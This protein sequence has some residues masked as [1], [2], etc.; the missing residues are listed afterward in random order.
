MKNILVFIALLAAGYNAFSQ[1]APKPYGALPSARQI[2]WQETD[3]YC[4]IHFSMATYTDKEWG[5]GDEDP[6]IFN[7][8]SFSAIQ[9][10]SAAKAGGF[11]G[12]VVVAKHHDGFCLW[13]TK[14]TKHNISYSPF[15][16][17]KGDLVKEYQLACLK[18]GMKMGVY[19]S[20]WDRNNALYGKPEY[21]T[22]V[23]QKQLEE[24]Y[25]N[26]GRL[27]MSWHDGANGGDG[28]YGGTCEVRKIDRSNYYDWTTTWGITRK[29]QPGASIFGDVGPDVRWVGNEDGHAGDPYWATYTPEAPEP[30][31]MPANGFVKDKEGTEGTRNGNNWMPAECDVPLRSGWFYHAS[32]AGKSKSA[33]TLLDLYYRSVGRG[34]C[35]DL[36]LSPNKDGELDNEDVAIL[37]QFGLLLKETFKTNYATG[38][39]FKA[40]NI[41]GNSSKFGTS[42]LLDNNRYSYW[43]TDDNVTNPKL[44]VN[45]PG[46]K[47]FNVIRLRENIKLGQ[48][49][50]GVTIDAWKS[51]SWKQIGTLKSIGANRLMRLPAN[52]TTNKLRLK[53]KSP[54]CIAL[55]D[56]G[57][58]KEPVHL[59]P[60]VI[61]PNN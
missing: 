12:I 42:N 7:P 25:A 20:P 22:E 50:D 3:M 38:A 47:T 2:N 23:Y 49:I 35:L 41:R 28:Y 31:K 36:G 57:L 43:A 45:L 34:A 61:T 6:S 30:G 10:V 8:K 56:L 19:C 14:T 51:N 39:T 46:I 44:T 13:P 21:V 11:K 1:T 53:F 24:L 54:V 59:Q 55:S 27:F 15:E 58:F 29:M 32:Q 52:V 5:D 48:R 37:N 40:S 26:Y 18:L 16:K 33:Y 17:G 60:P 9:I 4:I